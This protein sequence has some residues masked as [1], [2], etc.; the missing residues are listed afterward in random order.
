MTRE[1]L[2]S[3][4]FQS[5]RKSRVRPAAAVFAATAASARLHPPAERANMSR[6]PCRDARACGGLAG[7]SC[8]DSEERTMADPN[9]PRPDQA[10]MA[11]NTVA[12]YTSYE[13]AQQAV[14]RLS[15]EQFPVEN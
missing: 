12:T 14:D 1:M 6:R 9:L 3:A 15:D 7:C 2:A 11:W 10:S 5:S 4:T 8:P 13:E